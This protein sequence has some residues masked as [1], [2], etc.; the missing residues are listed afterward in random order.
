M[1]VALKRQPV[2][3]DITI[4]DFKFGNTGINHQTP[5]MAKA[6]FPA[7]EVA[8]K[9]LNCIYAFRGQKVMPDPDLAEIYAVAT[10][11]FHQRIKRNPERFPKILYLPLLPKRSII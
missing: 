3:L 10:K 7:L 9:M 2:Q 8:Q 4:C 11:R 5:V 1:P 6:A